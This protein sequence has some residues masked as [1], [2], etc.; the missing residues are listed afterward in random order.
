MSAKQDYWEE[1]ISDAASECELTLNET[2]LK[3]LAESIRISHENYGQ[4]F[5]QPPA[6]DRIA[7]IEGEWKRRLDSL[8]SK[9]DKYRDNA[10]TAVK[11]ALG[12]RSDTN[13]SIGEHGNVLRYGGR[14]EQIQ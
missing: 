9:F 1:C 12:Q 4:A 8:Q 7:N 6:S 10:E 13:V 5:Y 11:R 14:I 3:C 2:Q